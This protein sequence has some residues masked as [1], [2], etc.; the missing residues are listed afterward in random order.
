M[1]IK[2]NKTIAKEIEVRVPS[3]FTN[4][5]HTYKIFSE[6]NCIQVT[7]LKGHEAIGVHDICLPFNLNGRKEVDEQFYLDKLDNVLKVISAL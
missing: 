6:Q 3:Y 7:D 5:C 1:K 4:S 2:V